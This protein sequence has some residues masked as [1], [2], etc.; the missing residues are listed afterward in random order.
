MVGA[1]LIPT[2]LIISVVISGGT[3]R[4]GRALMLLEAIAA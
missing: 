4:T 3:L 2:T 1:L